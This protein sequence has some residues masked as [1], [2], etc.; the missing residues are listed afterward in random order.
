MYKP[1]LGQPA[2]GHSRRLRWGRLGDSFNQ[3]GP[4]AGQKVGGD[5]IK[6]GDHAGLE[7]SVLLGRAHLAELVCDPDV[8]CYRQRL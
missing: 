3:P 5:D 8:W 4:D 7:H 1:W 6:I 2:E